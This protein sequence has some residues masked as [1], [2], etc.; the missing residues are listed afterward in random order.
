M[1]IISELMLSM[2]EL[3]KPWFKK[4]KTKEMNTSYRVSKGN[5]I[6]VQTSPFYPLWLCLS[7]TNTRSQE[8]KDLNYF[9][10]WRKID[11]S[12]CL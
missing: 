7:N 4:N 3:S 12:H 1:E 2:N 10:K 9:H 8:E 11:N 6:L 5:L